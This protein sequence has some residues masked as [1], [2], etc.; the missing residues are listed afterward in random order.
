MFLNKK[1]FSNIWFPCGIEIES[2]VN[3]GNA[4]DCKMVAKIHLLGT[5]CRIKKGKIDSYHK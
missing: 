5:Y 1:N 4:R 3:Q 2:N